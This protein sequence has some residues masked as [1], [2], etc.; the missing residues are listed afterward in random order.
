[1][2]VCAFMG[3]ITMINQEQYTYI[4]FPISMLIWGWFSFFDPEDR[5]YLRRNGIDPDS[6][7]ALFPDDDPYNSKH[8]IRTN[9]SYCNGYGSR[10]N[11]KQYTPQN[12]PYNESNKKLNRLEY[13]AVSKKCKR[14]FK[15]TVND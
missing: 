5:E 11:Y 15:I 6:F 2:M 14:S 7:S 8:H 13:K 4:I 12:P 3:L 1:M 10:Y 9:D